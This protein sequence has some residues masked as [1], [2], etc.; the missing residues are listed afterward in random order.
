MSYYSKQNVCH[1]KSFDACHSERSEESFSPC[2]PVRPS[3]RAAK[4]LSEGSHP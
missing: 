3:A 4:S 1:L 2:H